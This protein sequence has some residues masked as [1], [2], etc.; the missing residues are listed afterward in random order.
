LPV[1]GGGEGFLAENAPK[2]LGRIRVLRDIPPEELLVLEGVCRYKRFRSGEQIFDHQSRTREVFFVVTGKVRIVNYSLAGREI[3]FDNID[4]GGQFG[5]LAAIDGKPRSAGAVALTES[6]IVSMS[7]RHFLSTMEKYPATA[8][9]I[10]QHLAALLRASTARIMDLSTLGA[11]NRVQADLVRLARAKSGKGNAA[12]LK[13][14]P[15]HGDIASRVSTTRETVARVLNDLARQ[16]II[17]R[18]KDALVVHDISQLEHLVEASQGEQPSGD[19]SAA[20][21]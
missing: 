12:T 4:A 14:I 13:P 10:M 2:V 11:N 1:I 21:G 3:T 6:L 15:V 17:E 16:G 8:L 18:T 7:A 9:R 5:E 20:S 19:V